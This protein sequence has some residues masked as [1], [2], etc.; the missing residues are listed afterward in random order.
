MAA[1]EVVMMLRP[2]VNVRQR[3]ARDAWEAD[4]GPIEFELNAAEAIPSGWVLLAGRISRNMLEGYGRLIVETNPR[5]LEFELPVSVTGTVFELVRLPEGIRRIRWRPSQQACSFEHTPFIVRKLGFAELR[6]LM[7][8]RVIGMWLDQPAER[9]RKAGLRWW[10]PF[11]DLEGQYRA[12]ASLR[13]YSK[14]LSYRDWIERFDRLSE[15]DRQRI[16]RRI[17]AMWPRP[18]FA[19]VVCGDD[20]EARARTVASLQAQ[21]YPHFSLVDGAGPFRTEEYV[22]VLRAGDQLSE[23]ALYWMAE[24]LRA[25][26]IAFAYAD[27]DMIDDEGERAA[28]RFKPDWSPEHLRSINYVGRWAVIRAREL[29]AAGGL[30]ALPGADDGHDLNLRVARCVA[31]GQV[32]HVPAV[33]YHRA[34]AYPAPR[35]LPRARHPLPAAPPLVSII[36]PTRD[37]EHLLRGCIESVRT[38]SSYRAHEIIVVDNQSRDPGALEYL[39]ELGQSAQARVLRF[40]RAFNYSA[41]NNFGVRHARGEVLVL[42]NNDTEVITADW[43]EEM[44]GHL[45]QEGVGVVG[46]KLLFAD[47]RVQHAGDAV[48]PGGCADHLHVGIA[49]DAGGYCDRAIVAQEVSAVTSACLMTFAGLYRRVGGLDARNVPVAFSDVDFC[50]RV[51]ELGYRVIFT[52]HARLHHLESA[53]RGKDLTAAQ[54]ARTDSAAGSMRRRWGRRLRHDP[55]YNPN[56]SYR[57]PDFSLGDAP[58][59]KKPWR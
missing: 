3:D 19:V 11:V 32:A 39:R 53:S 41:I 50:L 21:L 25:G 26:E 18:H 33:L 23:H 13:A 48:G 37:G 54:R 5:R 10:K 34:A 27:E 31:H 51:Q 30:G 15:P 56:L 8:R 42:L 6:W 29:A 43:L 17:A 55:F 46:A 7:A 28:P 2:A 38:K 49:A 4:G 35:P 16:R 59:V 9:R 44:L 14:S 36:V 45:Y 20:G 22:S 47:G 52:P 12:C 58:R 40:D 1:K 57:Q 24:T